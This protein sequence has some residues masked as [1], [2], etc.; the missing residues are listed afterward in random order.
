MQA[1]AAPVAV[2]NN[3]NIFEF[4]DFVWRGQPVLVTGAMTE[5]PAMTRWNHAYLR[6]A[7]VKDDAPLPMFYAPGPRDLMYG[8]DERWPIAE[9]ID[10]LW[11]ARPAAPYPE[12]SL[13]YL[14]QRGL[15]E[16]PGLLADVRRPLFYGHDIQ[17]VNLWIGNTG[18]WTPLH[19]DQAD[20]VMCQVAG[21]RRVRLY[22]PEQGRSLYPVFAAGPLDDELMPPYFSMVS[23]VRSA[24]LSRLPDF[25]G[26]EPVVDIEL[27]PGEMLYVPA[28]W[29]HF[30]E[31]TDGPGILVNFW[32]ALQ[33]GALLTA[34]EQQAE[35]TMLEAL[36][37]LLDRADPARRAALVSLVRAL[38]DAGKPGL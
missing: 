30:V 6:E 13:F 25:A 38:C 9:V 31:I 3:P 18:C 29:W 4:R 12:G 23:D 16:L 22:S 10:R 27:R 35:T 20:N 26:V 19:F 11:G 21:T 33:Y 5:W 7:A 36:R 34:D 17:A 15:Q 37:G 24:D 1:A 32:Y 14:K 28:Y 2:L 8:L